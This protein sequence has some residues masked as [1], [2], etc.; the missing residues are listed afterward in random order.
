[1][2][3]V[4]DAQYHFIYE[5]ICIS[6]YWLFNWLLIKNKEKNIYNLLYIYFIFIFLYICFQVLF[7]YFICN[8]KKNG[9]RDAQ[10][11]YSQISFI[12]CNTI[13]YDDLKC[14]YFKILQKN[15]SFVFSCYFW[16]IIYHFYIYINIV[17]LSAISHIRTITTVISVHMHTLNICMYKNTKQLYAYNATHVKLFTKLR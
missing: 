14:K 4:R 2:L 10:N 15:K 9:H 1:M 7:I 5:F 8:E 3:E 13:C 6:W 11:G 12:Y 16:R 17:Q